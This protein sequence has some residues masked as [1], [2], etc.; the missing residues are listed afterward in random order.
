MESATQ[1]APM[2]EVLARVRNEASEVILGKS[3]GDDESI[4][5]IEVQTSFSEPTPTLAAAPAIGS[6]SGGSGVGSRGPRYKV[7]GEYEYPAD[8]LIIP[9]KGDPLFNP[10]RTTSNEGVDKLEASF[11]AAGGWGSIPP[12]LVVADEELGGFRVVAGIRRTKAARRVGIPARIKLL[13]PNTPPSELVAVSILENENRTNT[14]PMA[15]A[16]SFEAFVNAYTSEALAE[17]YPTVTDDSYAP[18][19]IARMRARGLKILATRLKLDPKTVDEY[20]QLLNLIPAARKHLIEGSLA[21]RDVVDR[22]MG[23]TRMV[24]ADGTPNVEKQEAALARFF[25]V[26]QVQGKPTTGKQLKQVVSGEA[27]GYKPN[28]WEVRQMLS[29]MQELGD[30]D[31]EVKAELVQ[32]VTLLQFVK[33]ELTLQT[34][35]RRLPWLKR[36]FVPKDGPG[37]TGTGAE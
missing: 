24:N 13:D 36:V 14:N 7:G 4:G 20:L 35:K 21:M 37:A 5:S 8:E 16:E 18:A 11:K 15:K 34:A 31:P 9:S 23:L 28:P 19:A 26:A 6:N 33:G 2:S 27:V 30:E 12:V 17:E 29:R 32:A 22:G 1:A 25:K 10:A 3:P